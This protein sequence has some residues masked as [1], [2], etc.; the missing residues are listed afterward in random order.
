VN[1]R[2]GDP[3]T[4]RSHAGHQTGSLVAEHLRQ[5][6]AVSQRAHAPPTTGVPQIAQVPTSMVSQARQTTIFP[7]LASFHAPVRQLLPHEHRYW[8]CQTRHHWRR[9]CTLPFRGCSLRCRDSICKSHR[10]RGMS[11]RSR[12]SRFSDFTIKAYL[13]QIIVATRPQGDFLGDTA[14]PPLPHGTPSP[15]AART[16]P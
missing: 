15:M 13:N 1:R 5:I 11:H 7:R 16:S 10:R 12:S 3:P 8:I 14:S 6:V 9:R 2:Y 4:C